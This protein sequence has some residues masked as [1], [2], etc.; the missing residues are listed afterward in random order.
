MLAG[1]GK[2][3]RSKTSRL[4]RRTLLGGAAA[5]AL[6]AGAVAYAILGPDRGPVI[7]GPFSLVDGTGKRWT[8]KDFLGEFLLVYFGYTFCPDVCPTALGELSAALDGMPPELVGRLRVVF[9]SVDPQRDHGERLDEYGK[10]FHERIM[11]LTGTRA[12][13]DSVAAAYGAKY[14]FA[15]DTA[16]Q[17]YAID[18]TSIIY[19]MGP[20][21]RFVTQFTHNATPEQMAAK[22]RAVIGPA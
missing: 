14:R 9:I 13:I 6:T 4:S 2:T 5:I 3:P 7:G 19:V 22:L 16:T 8:D 1:T 20:D 17:D 12:E 15:G 18:H 10:A 11:G 21:G